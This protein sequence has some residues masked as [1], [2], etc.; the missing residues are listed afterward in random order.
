MENITIC[1]DMDGTIADLYARETWLDELR[2]FSP[3]PYAEAKPMVNMSALARRLNNLQKKGYKIAIISWL[4]KVSTTEYDE[5]VTE[6]K[7]AWLKKHLPSVTWDE[8]HIVSYGET[9]AQ[10]ANG[11]D[12]LFDDEERN[13]TEWSMVDDNIAYPP[14]M[15][16]STLEALKTMF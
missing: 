12:I 10:F 4:S 1:F 9:K 3:L 13:R 16:I 6:A 14:E 5:I 8:I 2:V 7:L 15:I 11:K